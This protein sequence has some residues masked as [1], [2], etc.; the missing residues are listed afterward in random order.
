MAKY[1]FAYHGGS[2]P[3]DPDSVKKVMDAWGVWFGSM[4]AAVIDAGK[5][6]RQVEHSQKRRITHLRRRCKSAFRLQPD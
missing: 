6:G 2:A 3:T 4:G 1:V 5:S